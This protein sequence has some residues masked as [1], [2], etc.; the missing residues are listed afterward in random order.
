[1]GIHTAFADPKCPDLIEKD[2][3]TVWYRTVKNFNIIG[4]TT[5]ESGLSEAQ[6]LLGYPDADYANHIQ[7]ILKMTGDKAGDYTKLP[8]KWDGGAFTND[9]DLDYEIDWLKR[10]CE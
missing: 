1:M 7:V 3:K 2:D 9:E 6:S 5:G 8:K 10:I 4:I